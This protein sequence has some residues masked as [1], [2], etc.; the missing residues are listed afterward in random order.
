[1]DLWPLSYRELESCYWLQPGRKPCSRKWKGAQPSEAGDSRHPCK[2]TSISAA[3]PQ[4]K[5]EVGH[6]DVTSSTALFHLTA[7]CSLPATSVQPLS[8]LAAAFKIKNAHRAR[9]RS[10]ASRDVPCGHSCTRVQCCMCGDFSQSA[11]CNGRPTGRKE[12]SVDQCES[13]Q[14]NNGAT[15]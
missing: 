5:S 2:R 4:L 8:N 10:S 6:Q 3:Q 12:L 15:D 9:W 7:L 1:M 14:I 11:I 13:T